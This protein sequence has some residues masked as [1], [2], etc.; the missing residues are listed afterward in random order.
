MDRTGVWRLG[1]E[2]LQGE[3]RRRHRLR[4]SIGYWLQE[5]K[6]IEEPL[7]GELLRVDLKDDLGKIDIPM[8][9]IVV[10]E[11][12]DTPWYLVQ[13]EVK[14]YGGSVDF[15]IFENSHH[16]PFIDEERLFAETVIQFLNP[17]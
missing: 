14:S 6:Q 16:M 7:L 10:R 1:A 11:D 8:L 15:R 4:G 9:C 13:E 17:E 12:V 3:G 2:P 5:Q